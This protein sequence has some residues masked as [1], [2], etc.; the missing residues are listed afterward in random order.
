MLKSPWQ[1]FYH[2]FHLILDTLSRKTSVL[3][4]SEVLGLSGN[5]LTADHMY[6]PHYLREISATR[7]SAI[8]LK[9]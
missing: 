2:K 3:V 7:L 9:T 5:T 1:Q 8:I 6:S 4:R